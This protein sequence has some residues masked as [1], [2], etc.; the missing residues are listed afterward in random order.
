MGDFASPLGNPI[1][2]GF[3]TLNDDQDLESCLSTWTEPCTNI[4]VLD[5]DQ[6]ASAMATAIAL[7]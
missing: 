1:Y 2:Q 6:R 3:L 4:S 7:P 5:D